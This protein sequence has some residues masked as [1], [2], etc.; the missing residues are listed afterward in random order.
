M[1]TLRE[2][3]E[4][5]DDGQLSSVGMMTAIIDAIEAL[6]TLKHERDRALSKLAVADTDV[7]RWRAERELAL[8]ERDGMRWDRDAAIARA[9]RAEQTARE[10]KSSAIET[11]KERDAAI[12]RAERAEK[13]RDEAH[14][15]WRA[16]YEGMYSLFYDVREE[17][18][19]ARRERDEALAKLADSRSEDR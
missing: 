3:L 5:Y 19:A 11:G 14:N 7:T 10:W 2:K 4:Q 6:A 9:E 8:Q 12:A 1:T 13:E 15:T 17:R 18:D 16:K